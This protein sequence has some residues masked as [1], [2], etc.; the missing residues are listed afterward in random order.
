[1]PKIL[2]LSQYLIKLLKF[3]VFEVL[4][5]AWTLRRKMD[6]KGL[7]RTRNESLRIADS[8]LASHRIDMHLPLFHTVPSNDPEY[9][10]AERDE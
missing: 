2:V 3:H 4:L 9:E 1:C 7:K 6:K 10:D 8:N 5:E